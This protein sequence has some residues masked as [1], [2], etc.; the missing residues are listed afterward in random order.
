MCYL[1]DKLLLR[2][3]NYCLTIG[4]FRNWIQDDAYVI[5]LLSAISSD[6]QGDGLSCPWLGF[7]PLGVV[8]KCTSC[9]LYINPPA[10]N[11]QVGI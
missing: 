6:G 5:T 7:D 4:V 11:G 3:T 2:L 9:D 10:D 8:P 1:H